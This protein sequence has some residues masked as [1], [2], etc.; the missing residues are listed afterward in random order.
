[1]RRKL[2]LEFPCA[3]ASEMMDAFTTHREW[4]D[5][6]ARDDGVPD[7]SRAQD[8]DARRRTQYLGDG[9]RRRLRRKGKVETPE[10]PQARDHAGDDRSEPQERVRQEGRVDA[11]APLEPQWAVEGDALQHASCR[12]AISS[13]RRTSATISSRSATSSS[14]AIARSRSCASRS[15]CSSCRA[16]A[17]KAPKRSRSACTGS[18]RRSRPRATRSTAASRISGPDA[19]LEAALE[20]HGPVA[21]CAHVR[22]P[23]T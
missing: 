19:Q 18:A 7:R 12:R 22:T 1:M 5:M 4:A 20:A 23:T 3:R 13:R 15:S 17:M 2:E 16:Q 14:A 6:V 9:R 21:R 11:G 10:D 8:V